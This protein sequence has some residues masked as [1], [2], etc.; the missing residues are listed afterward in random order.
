MFA[1]KQGGTSGS[2]TASHQHLDD[3]CHVAHPTAA[4]RM[5]ACPRKLPQA[6]LWHTL[7]PGSTTAAAQQTSSLRLTPSAGICFRCSLDQGC[8]TFFACC[9][10]QHVLSQMGGRLPLPSPLQHRF[11]EGSPLAMCV[12]SVG[13]GC[14]S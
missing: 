14:L 13:R 5:V 4:S 2:S 9:P 11:C 7:G 8:C 12:L 6:L 1:A 3:Q 10:R